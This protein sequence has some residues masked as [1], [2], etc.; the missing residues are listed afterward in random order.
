MSETPRPLLPLRRVG[1]LLAGF[2]VTLALSVGT[3]AILRMVGLFPASGT[4][5]SSGLFALAALYRVLYGVVGCAV[6]ARL[7]PD[8][9]MLHALILSGLGL[10][11]STAGTVGTWNKGPEF[12]PKWYPISLIVTAVPGGWLG[13]LWG[14]RARPRGIV[15]QSP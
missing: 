14:A 8:R 10:L 13:G 1:A 11:L 12:G 6:A 15:A 3:D 4:A 2:V 5:M 9:P 7:A